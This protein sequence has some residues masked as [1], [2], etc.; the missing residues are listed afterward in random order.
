MLSLGSVIK[1]RLQAL[2]ALDGWPVSTGTENVDRRVVPLADVRCVAA[3][4][5]PSRNTAAQLAPQWVIT[6]AVKA[7]AGA[8]AQLDAALVAVIGSLHNWQPGLVSGLGWGPLRSGGAVEAAMP[9]E[10]VVA[11]ELS[12]STEALFPGQ[13]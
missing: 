4:S 11:Y 7:G 6:L 13:D 3:Q 9:P 5:L 12:F 2:P 1:S 10:G 8:E